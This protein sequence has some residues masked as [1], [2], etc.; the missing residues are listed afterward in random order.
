[1]DRRALVHVH[2]ITAALAMAAACGGS[3]F[4]TGGGDDGGASDGAGPDVT[5]GG[6]DGGQVEAG[7]PDAIS[8]PDVLEEPPPTCS[9]QYACVP[10]V[11]SGWA[12]P[13]EVYAGA[14]QAPPC[15]PL[16][17]VAQDAHDELD[18]GPATCGCQCGG[19]KVV[20]APPT[21]S[22]FNVSGCAVSAPCATKTLSPQTC[23][24]VDLGIACKGLSSPFMTS[25][26]A[27][28]TSATCAAQATQSVPPSSWGIN[29]RACVSAVAP[30]QVDCPSGSICAPKPALPFG[31]AACIAV[32]GDVACPA[33]RYSNRHVYFTSLNDSRGCTTCTCGDAGNPTCA[34]TVATHQPD[35]SCTDLGVAYQAP[36]SCVPVDEP[37][38][39]EVTLT[40]NA[41]ACPPSAS[42]P[43][44]S[45]SGMGAVTVCCN[46]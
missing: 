8:L 20:C 10:A 32:L 43:S 19:P 35:A 24:P 1:M 31:P 16:F 21:I 36:F 4:T 12:G 11:P 27:T 3:A 6:P 23:T 30:A 7:G 46:Q 45:A 39:Y 13:L 34:A 17:V 44:G 37:R 41:G 14:A 33:G 5:V 26:Q 25:P 29:G 18:A 28:V 40:S 2:A 15:S 9:G 42:I 38:D 22:F